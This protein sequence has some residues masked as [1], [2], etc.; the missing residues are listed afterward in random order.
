MQEVLTIMRSKSKI[1]PYDLI[2]LILLAS[3]KVNGRTTI[4][5]IG[6]FSV[7]KLG[8]GNDYVP[9]YYGPYSPRLASSLTELVSVGL[10]DEKYSIT[11]NERKMY[12][13]SLTDYGRN[14]TSTLSKRFNKEFKI[15]NNIVNGLGDVDGDRIEILSCAAKIHYLAAISKEKLTYRTARE[16]AGALGWNLS[17]QQITNSIN[18]LRNLQ[19]VG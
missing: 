12:S 17:N 18:I 5:K 6:Y 9:H 8:I 16:K 14:Y 2:L 15:I 4:Q 1:D 10:V 7:N 3:D 19:V 13:Y 11:N